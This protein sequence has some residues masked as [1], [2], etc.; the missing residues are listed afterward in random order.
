MTA[1][2]YLAWEERQELKHEYIDGEVIEMPGATWDHDSIVVNISEW[3]APQLKST[4]CRLRTSDMRIQIAGE[5]YVYADL[6]AVCG[7]PL[8]SRDRMNLLNL[9]FVLE[10]T[11]TSSYMYDRVDKLGFYLDVPSIAAYLIVEQE[12]MRVDLCTRA[13]GGWNMRA[14]AKP[15]DVIPLAAL[16]CELPLAEIYSGIEIA[17]RS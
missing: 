11:S 17:D 9:V 5:R 4:A 15:D 16:E 7:Q 8:L 2:E 14:Y 13:D 1:A 10:V 12:R 3:L 6:S